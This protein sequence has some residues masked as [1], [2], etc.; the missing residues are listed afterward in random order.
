MVVFDSDCELRR[1]GLIGLDAAALADLLALG[2]KVRGT[3]GLLTNS[4]PAL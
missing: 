4:T 1:A 2:I 3:T